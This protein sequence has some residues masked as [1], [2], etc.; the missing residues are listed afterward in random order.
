MRTNPYRPALRAIAAAI[1]TEMEHELDEPCPRCWRDAAFLAEL[2][3][4]SLEPGRL[5]A[6]AEL[7]ADIRHKTEEE[8][9]L[10]DE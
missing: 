7:A 10:P 3:L 9:D 4:T 8:A 1:C 5:I 6:P 2:F